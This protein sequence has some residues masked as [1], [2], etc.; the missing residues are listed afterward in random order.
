M[1]R[2][3]DPPENKPGKGKPRAKG[4]AKSRARAFGWRL[5][6]W[7]LVGGVWCVFL[8]LCFVAWLA[9]DLPDLS[10]L[11]NADRRASI[12]LVTDDGQILASYGDLYGKPVKLDQIP[13]YLP[14]AL[15]ATEDR[16][17]YSHFG[18]DPLGLLR[19]I[20]ANVRAGHL[21]QGGSTIT[22][23]LAKN[24]FLTPDRTI[25]RKGQELL[26]ALWLEHN[27]TKQQIL[28]LYLN[29]V[30]FGAG[31]YGVEAAARKYFGKSAS[32]VTPFEAAM[33]VGMVKA[34]SRYNPLSDLKAA[35]DRAKVVLSE[36]A[37]TGYITAADADRAIA[38]GVANF[39][40]P[41]SA[42]GQYYAD[43]VMD[44]VS[45]YVNYDDRDLVVVTTIDRRA[46]AAAEVAVAKIL[47]GADASKNA[48]QAALI[49]I[50]PDGAVRALVGGRDYATSQ[51][52]RA[53]QSLRPPGS[54]FK[55]FVYLAAMEAGMTPDDV[56]TD[57]PF[58]V[59]NYRPNNYDDKFYGRVSLREAFA[60]SLNSVAL[61][62]SERVGR[63]RVIEAARRLGVTADLT[64]GPSIAL[65]AS[66]VSLLEMTGAYAAF[67]NKG[68][69]VWPYGID[70]ILDSDGNVLYQRSGGGP[71]HVVGGHAAAEMIDMMQSVILSG[72]GKAAALDRP[73]AGKTGTSQDYRDALFIGFTADLVTG[74]WVGNDDNTPMNKVTGGTLPTRIWH[75]FM[76]AAEAGKPV[77]SLPA[78]GGE[79]PVVALYPAPSSIATASVKASGVGGTNVATDPQHPL[80]DSTPSPEIQNIIDKLKVLAQQR[81]K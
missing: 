45:G 63:H 52:N 33:L 78:P 60:H 19:A 61:Q 58:A 36:M 37:N 68:N 7:T 9:Y 5:L 76:M 55:L 40:T 41:S 23:Q 10:R 47:A 71:G 67:A 11:T 79:L 66:G 53:T 50:S 74:V 25:R 57:A 77:L 4:R 46:Q 13:P 31:T 69:G 56:M 30:Y 35:E 48:S 73:A 14:D 1:S 34:P 72:T 29:R 42:T 24:V 15:L 12:T 70:Q 8:G 80:G 39:K 32:Q 6:K 65:G 64:S 49:A 22:Q 18:V 51:F 27:M 26:L 3:G 21:V 62:V 54:S 38:Q 44:Q 20:I 43:W 2:T 28:T 75:D 16:R 17:F 59:G 81:Q